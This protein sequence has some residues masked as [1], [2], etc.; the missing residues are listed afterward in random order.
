MCCS[1]GNVCYIQGAHICGRAAK[2]LKTPGKISTIIGLD[3]GSIRL[4][5]KQSENRLDKSDA[6]YVEVIHTDTKRFGIA[7][8]IGHGEWLIIFSMEYFEYNFSV[9]LVDFFPNKGYSQPGCRKTSLLGLT[10]KCNI[11]SKMVWLAYV[12]EFDEYHKMK[13]MFGADNSFIS[14]QFLRLND[15]FDDT[16]FPLSHLFISKTLSARNHF[17]NNCL[18]I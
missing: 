13:P 16:P 9:I 7:T 18:L 10:G 17:I 11:P 2:A 4:S 5:N 6:D 12:T 3:P 8:P 15:E 1:C 14:E